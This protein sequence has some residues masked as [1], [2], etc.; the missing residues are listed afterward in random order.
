[1]VLKLEK[2]LEKIIYISIISWILF[3]RKFLIV[4]VNML[5]FFCF[6]SCLINLNRGMFGLIGS[7]IFVCNVVFSFGFVLKILI[8]IWNFLCVLVFKNKVYEF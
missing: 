6:F 5:D 4:L 2:W 3:F 7:L 1:M 8:K